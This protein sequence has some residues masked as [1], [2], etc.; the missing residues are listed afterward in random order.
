[1]L[2]EATLFVKVACGLKQHGPEDTLRAPVPSQQTCRCDLQPKGAT[3]L[4]GSRFTESLS[5]YVRLQRHRSDPPRPQMDL[6]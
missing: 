2:A 3:L 5:D 4:L 6:K 1:M